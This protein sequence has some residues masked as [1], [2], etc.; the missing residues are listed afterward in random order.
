VFVRDP[1]D[2]LRLGMPATVY[3]PLNG[4]ADLHGGGGAPA[5]R[6]A[7]AGPTDPSDLPAAPAPAAPS[8][9]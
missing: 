3:L 6:P 5:L 7:P 9:R 4:A 1:D 2:Q 8:P